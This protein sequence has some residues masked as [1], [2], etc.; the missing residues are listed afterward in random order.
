MPIHR[1]PEVMTVG[2]WESFLPLE[3]S[4]PLLAWKRVMKTRVRLHMNVF[5]KLP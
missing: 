1:F 4:P 3:Q 2:I 5:G